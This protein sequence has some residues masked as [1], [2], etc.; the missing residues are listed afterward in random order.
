VILNPLLVVEVLSPST[1]GYDRG[2]KLDHYKSTESL[3]EYL[4]VDQDEPRVILHTRRDDHWELR[5]VR[6][7]DGSV[8]LSSVGDS[9]AMSDIYAKIKFKIEQP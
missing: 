1:K 2:D 6:G 7:I 3:E 8:Y 9:L 4:L 5:E